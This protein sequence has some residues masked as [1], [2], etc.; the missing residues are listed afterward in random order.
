MDATRGVPIHLPRDV[1]RRNTDGPRDGVVIGVDAGGTKTLAVALDLLTGAVSVGRAGPA[2][3]DAV[4]L[5][6]GVTAIAEAVRGACAG[7]ED[8]RRILVAGAGTDAETLGEHVRAAIPFSLFVNDVVAAW[9]TVAH[10]APAIAVISG[11]GSNALGVDAEHRAIRCGG[12]GHV[13]G[14][15]G[16]GWWIGREAV[17]V[18]LFDHDGRGRPTALSDLVSAEFNAADPGAAAIALYADGAPKS[19]VAALALLVVAAA[20][21]GDDVATE[22]LGEAGALL[23]D[24]VRAIADALR[25]D[26]PAAMAVGLTG[27]TWKAGGALREVFDA[28]VADRLPGA[29]IERVEDAPV[30]GALALALHACGRSDAVD[31]LVPAAARALAE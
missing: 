23:A 15:E 10:G 13:F 25:I 11:T 21:E 20:G 27:S 3:P 7:R 30:T 22:I 26:D 24:H 18:A 1:A 2:N 28:A 4:G 6:V 19:R 8:V 31:A 14:D 9:A 17:R 5:P 16:S 12:W 29:R